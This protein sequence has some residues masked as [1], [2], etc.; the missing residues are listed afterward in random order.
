M[1][2]LEEA[3][4]PT[5]DSSAE[6]LLAASELSC[7]RGERL[8]FS[9][10]DL[11]VGAYELLQIHG[12]NGSGKT[13]LL[14]ILCGL[15]LPTEGEIRWRGTNIHS[16]SSEYFSEILHVGHT[17]GIKLELSPSEN[18]RFAR[19]LGNQPTE[20][21]VAEVLERL[22]LYG[23]EDVPTRTLSAGQRRRV[24]LARLLLTHAKLWI[25]DEPFTSLDKAGIGAME[26]LLTQHLDQGGMVILSSHSPLHLGNRPMKELHLFS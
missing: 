14:R 4:L 13:T 24:A 25:L 17:D 1:K 12:P 2:N 23:F 22:D 3:V 26:L 20:V 16:N 15:T 11:E 21:D 10:V 19:S 9:R 6:P 8:L 5:P 7:Y 18:L